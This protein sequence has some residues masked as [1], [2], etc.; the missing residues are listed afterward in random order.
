MKKILILSVVLTALIAGCADN[1]EIV[2]EQ[3][4]GKGRTITLT[5]SMP[6]EGSE[7][8]PATGAETRIAL[9]PDGKNIKLTWQASDQ[10][11]LCFVQGSTKVKQTVAVSDISVDGKRATFD[12]TIPAEITT[13]T[14]DLYGMYGGGGLSDT[15]PTIA[16]LPTGLSLAGDLTGVQNQKHVMLKF[17]QT[18][19]DVNNPSISVTFSHLGSLFSVRLKNTSAASWNDIAK[20]KIIADADAAEWLYSG[21]DGGV[22]YNL[23]SGTFVSGPVNSNYMAFDLSS[24]IKLPAGGEKQFWGW[25]PPVSDVPSLRLEVL[26]SSDQILAQSSNSRP[27]RDASS[28]KSYY[29][30]AV[31]DGTLLKFADDA[32]SPRSMMEDLSVTGDIMHAAEG[33]DF[34]G[35]VYSK[36][37]SNNIYYNAAKFDG[38]WT[39]ETLLGEGTEARIAIDGGNHPHVVY[40]TGG[41]II[42]RTTSDGTTWNMDSITSNYGGT[43]SSPDISVDAEGHADI[44]YTDSNGDGDGY[45]DIMYAENSSGTFVKTLIFNGFYDDYGGSSAYAEYYNK[46]SYIA[47]DQSGGP[48]VVTHRQAIIKAPGWNDNKYHVVVKSSSASGETSGTYK[49]DLNDSYD[50]AFNG[51]D[52]VALFKDNN[53]NKTAVLQTSGTDINFTN[54]SDI[55]TT[56]VTPTSLSVNAS[57]TVVSGYVGS[58]LFTKYDA[59]ENTY[60]G[61]TIKSGTKPAVVN[62]YGIFYAVYTDNAGS[63]KIVRVKTSRPPIYPHQI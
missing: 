30:Y 49:T 51:T 63:V 40:T 21:E 46:K 28:G 55:A 50:I 19:I 20:I 10:L 27:S 32:F 2:E 15:D 23:V 13:G 11:Q 41:Q 8:A 12:I 22:Q 58:T 47:I 54:S 3:Q 16:I 56:G 17:S 6:D 4:T 9:T 1:K 34:I 62:V 59:Y 48:F 5:A 60:S 38:T 25:Y 43:C 7:T 31:W 44:S 42:Y 18:G 33:T 53:V 37:G 45:R 57:H 61:I 52:V 14:F 36:T 26:N 24:P 35:I 39:G 29:F